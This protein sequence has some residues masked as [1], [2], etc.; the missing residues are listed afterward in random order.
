MVERGP[1]SEDFGGP[2]ELPA[3]ES[4]ATPA[5]AVPEQTQP[6]TTAEVILPELPDEKAA[7]SMVSKVNEPTI[8]AIANG[9]QTTDIEATQKTMN[10]VFESN[11]DHAA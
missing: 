11:I 4:E 3:V 2:I 7:Q 1:R 6:N 8:E 5:V 9:A 10:T